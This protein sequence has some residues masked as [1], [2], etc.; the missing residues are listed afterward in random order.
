MGFF[1]LKIIDGIKPRIKISNIYLKLIS[2]KIYQ[3]LRL[4]RENI[5]N[6]IIEIFLK[7]MCLILVK[8]LKNKIEPIK[9]RMVD[10]S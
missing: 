9:V 4:V 7:V 10:I 3:K 5:K 8:K 6:K 1:L 2:L